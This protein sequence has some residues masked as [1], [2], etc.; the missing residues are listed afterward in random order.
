MELLK[1]A[2]IALGDTHTNEDQAPE[3]LYKAGHYVDYRYGNLHLP[4]DDLRPPLTHFPGRRA[5]RH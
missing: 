4:L 3:D 2:M 5:R 1:E